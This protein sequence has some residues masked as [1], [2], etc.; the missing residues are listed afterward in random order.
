MAN[1]IFASNHRSE[2]HAL[3]LSFCLVPA[4][5]CRPAA[6][7]C[8]VHWHMFRL[9]SQF[10]HPCYQQMKRLSVNVNV[11][12]GT[13]VNIAV[14]AFSLHRAGFLFYA[15]KTVEIATVAATAAS[16]AAAAGASAAA[17]A[18]AGSAASAAAAASST[19]DFGSTAGAAAA[20]TAAAGGSSGAAS[21]AGAAAAAA[22]AAGSQDEGVSSAAAA[23]AAASG[24][25]NRPAIFDPANACF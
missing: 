21:A 6:Y 13:H 7:G 10:R 5:I 24:D 11:G 3:L 19:S 1:A 18:A 17:A 8:D 12:P 2:Y 4:P 14:V 20:A 16:S 23:A 9:A 25:G 22:A 15:G